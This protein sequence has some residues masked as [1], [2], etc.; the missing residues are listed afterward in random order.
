M[1]IKYGWVT[2]TAFDTHKEIMLTH[3]MNDTRFFMSYKGFT[4]IAK[5]FLKKRGYTIKK[6]DKAV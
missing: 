3:K 1:G 6:L 4:S 5:G 2:L